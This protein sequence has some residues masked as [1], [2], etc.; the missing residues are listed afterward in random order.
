MRLSQF[1][2][3]K[4]KRQ[5]HLLFVL[6][7][8]F[9]DVMGVGLSTPI[10]PKLI[11]EFVGGDVSTAAYYFGAA[12]TTNALMLFLFSP[13]QGA[14]SDR[15]GR[16]P[17]LLYSLLGTGI[18]YLALTLAPNLPCIFV[19]QAIGG[20]ASASVAV[21]S[22]YI[23]D[24]SSPEERGKNFGLMGATFGLGWIVGPALGGLL[25][26]WGLRFPFL[27]AAIITFLNLLYGYFIVP[28]SL[29][30]ENRRPFCWASANPIASLGL[31]WKNSNILGLAAII[32]CADLAVQCFVSTWVLFT[33]H[34]FQWT[35]LDAGLSLTLLGVMTA[36]VQGGLIRL[37][38][39][40]YGER[41]TITFGLILSLI[42]YLLYAF[43]SQGWMM[44]LVIVLNGFD[45][46][47]KPTALGLISS[48]V[49][50][51]EQGAIQGALTSQSALTSVIGPLV[52]TNLFGYFTSTSAPF[53][54]PEV[55][56]FLGA[57][58][59]GIGL[60]LANSTFAKHS[61]NLKSG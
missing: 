48:Q 16:R 30:Q 5:S 54:F 46:V 8:L 25:G 36:I 17:V 10:L 33:T 26:S 56:F 12:I 15:F 61:Y 6:I 28:E 13:L 3:M 29:S 40:R 23:A 24:I 47:V 34:K 60:W 57:L 22:A 37:I 53:R 35:A 2:T 7:T 55:A 39:S 52:A 32:L 49:S 14:L 44:Y 45:F 59:F 4:K 27:L 18:S 42:G 58:L 19:A 21:V 43:P 20:F 38:I 50:A 1:P 51:R 9:L 31:L 11:A 41:K